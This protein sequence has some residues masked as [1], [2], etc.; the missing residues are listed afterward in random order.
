ML[1]GHEEIARFGRVVRGLFGDV[2]SARAIGVFPVSGKGLSEDW[3]ERLL[4]ASASSTV[5]TAPQLRYSIEY[6][7]RHTEA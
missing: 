5:R 6:G 4:H 7:G 1:G 3:I 2:V